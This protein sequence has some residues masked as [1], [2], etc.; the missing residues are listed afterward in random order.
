MHRVIRAC[1]IIIYAFF[2]FP[3]DSQNQIKADSIREVIENQ[4][5]SSFEELEA[6]Y[7]LS[8]YSSSPEDE[9][10]YGVKALELSKKLN[11][12]EYII[13][14]NQRI[15]VAHRLMGDLGKALEYLFESAN[16][17]LGNDEYKLLLLEAYAEISTCYTQNGDSENAFL[18]GLKTIEILRK[19]DRKQALALSLL[20]TGYDYYLIANYDSAMALYNES[21]SIL[22]EIKMDIGLAYLTGNRALVYW[23]KGE[24][25]KAKKD[26][27]QAIE[28]LEPFGD[29][30]GQSDYY[31]QLG[32]IFFEEGD[33]NKGIVY[34]SKGLET[35]IEE[36]L[37]EQ[38]RDASYLL[39]QLHQK[40]NDHKKAIE[41]QTQYYAY[42][43]SIQNL[44]T[45]QE[46]A[47]IRTGFEVGQKQA[48]VDLLMAQKKSNQIIM[49]TGG[50]ILAVVI[51]IAIMAYSY[52]KSKSR[53]NLK[54]NEQ[55]DSLVQ[56]NSTKDKFFSIVSHD[57]RGPV[58]TLSGLVSITKHYLD[59]NSTDQLEDMID[60]MEN[61]TNRLT[62]LLDNLLHWAL[63]QRG[64]ISYVPEKLD[65]NILFAELKDMFTDMAI[66]KNINLQIETADDLTVFADKN[67]VST[68]FRNLV[69]NAVKFTKSG[70]S[71]KIFAEKRDDLNS[72]SIQFKDSGIGIQKDKLDS[73]FT[74][75]ENM[76]T[77]GTSGESGLGLG[78][79]LVYEFIQLNKGEIQVES[80]EGKG[81]SFTVM[82]PL[83]D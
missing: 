83:A 18:Y 2:V 25:E 4:N 19:T 75:T 6:Y 61:S 49:I 21:E 68:I 30:Y 38:A 16:E 29:R 33:Q 26:L 8:A 50:I 52:S 81:T 54:L 23:K 51:C 24:T 62:R 17:A 28:M 15:G 42:K 57:L 67:A 41:F 45:T 43:D 80:E 12:K 69:N 53:L 70:G 39:F 13:K 9:L 82:L 34:T 3:A 14:S 44:E 64:Q 20:N 1:L 74:L 59:N 79:Q 7:R 37:K 55:K 63:Q 48:E 27:F 40:N 78:L 76:P 35:A 77:K 5:L 72:A 47:N 58:S 56:L 46:L 65:V 22:K 73:L 10:E 32:N 31:N 60:K 66:S 11:N 71:I 36:G